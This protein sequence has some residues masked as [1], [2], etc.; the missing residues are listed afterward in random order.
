[1]RLEVPEDPARSE[2]ELRAALALARETERLMFQTLLD[3]RSAASLA[4]WHTAN[5]E[6]ESLSRALWS[7]RGLEARREADPFVNAQRLEPQWATARAMIESEGYDHSEFKCQ[8]LNSF[9][10]GRCRLVR[11]LRLTPPGVVQ[12]PSR[13]YVTTDPHKW[14][15]QLRKDLRRGEFGAATLP[16][17]TA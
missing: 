12:P 10:D 14:I 3:R 8:I 13:A 16:P 7:N 11:V 17:A 1:M 15:L 6:T 9:E 4:D 2:I 5:A